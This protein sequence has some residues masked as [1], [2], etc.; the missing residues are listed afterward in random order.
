MDET[1]I[2]SYL[3][4]RRP[5]VELGDSESSKLQAAA[6]QVLGDVL[7]GDVGEALAETLQVDRISVVMEDDST[8]ALELEK[9]VTDTI[10]VRYQRA[11]RASY[12]DKLEI[13]WRFWKHFSLQSE[14]STTGESGLDLIWSYDY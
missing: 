10:T 7:L 6:T 2:L 8:P 14:V 4:F 1:E 5:S 3:L 11:L 9:R 13:D 12:G